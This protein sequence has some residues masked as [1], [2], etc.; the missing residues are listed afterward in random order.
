MIIYSNKNLPRKN[1]NALRLCEALPQL[2]NDLKNQK[3]NQYKKYFYLPKNQR[4]QS[5]ELKK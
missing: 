4:K 5:A 3:K 1:M 2:P